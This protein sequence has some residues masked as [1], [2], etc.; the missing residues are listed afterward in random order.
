MPVAVLVSGQCQVPSEILALRFL[1][2]PELVAGARRA[3]HHDAPHPSADRR[4][5]SR[6]HDVGEAVAGDVRHQRDPVAEEA[7]RPVTVPAPDRHAAR[8]RP[9]GGAAALERVL[10]LEACASGDVGAPVAV[11]IER[12][13]EAKPELTPGNVA[14]EAARDAPAGARRGARCRLDGL[15]YCESDKTEEEGGERRRDRASPA[16]GSRRRPTFHKQQ[17]TQLLPAMLHCTLLWS[18]P[19]TPVPLLSATR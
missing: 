9:D 3:R 7:V 19:S 16:R 18:G 6:D 10:E 8:S 12:L 11:G 14:G 4:V 2:P 17:P 1:A 15:W 5:R 13:A